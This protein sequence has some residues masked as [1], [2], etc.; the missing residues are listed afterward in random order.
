MTEDE[1]K[2]F[3]LSEYRQIYQGNVEPDQKD[4]VVQK[5]RAQAITNFLQDCGVEQ[6][7]HFVDIGSSTGL[8]LEKIK[9]KYKCEV[10]GI[11]PGNA[12][13]EFAQSRG[14]EVFESLEAMIAMGRRKFDLITMIHVLEHIPDPVE[15]LRQL[16]LNILTEPGKVL[17]EVPNIYAHDSFE[18]AHLTSFSRH[19]LVEV[20]KE[21]GFETIF[22]EPHGRPRSN[23]IPLYISLLATP[24]VTEQEKSQVE[25]ERWIRLKRRAGLA[26]RKVIEK[27]FPRQAWLPEYRS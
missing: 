13:R 7:K 12:Y 14:L 17:V 16:R 2:V 26:H 22:L 8:L 23:M 18:V 25:K 27:L 10:I 15:Y 1:L 24:E 6:V 11:E 21:A 3:Y 9:N 20:L 19:S 4:I 5:A